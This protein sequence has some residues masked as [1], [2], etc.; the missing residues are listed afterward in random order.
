MKCVWRS[1]AGRNPGLLSGKLCVRWA[2]CC[3][4]P[5]PRA[6]CPAAPGRSSTEPPPGTHCC[7]QT[8]CEHPWSGEHP[9]A[10]GY[11]LIK[12]VAGFVGINTVLRGLLL[13]FEWLRVKTANKMKISIAVLTGNKACWLNEALPDF[14]LCQWLK[15][16]QFANVSP[17][18]RV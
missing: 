4:P 6:V 9:W 17:G 2:D 13:V 16:Q 18:R 15:M 3:W 1:P 8:P 14:L 5:P 7:A 12:K 11:C 10:R